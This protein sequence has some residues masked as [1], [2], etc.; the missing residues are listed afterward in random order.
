[1]EI[2]SE[3]IVDIEKPAVGG[4]IDFPDDDIGNRIEGGAA[5][6]TRIK[7][8][9]VGTRPAP[10]PE[11]EDP[12]HQPESNESAILESIAPARKPRARSTRKTTGVRKTA[13]KRPSTR[14]KRE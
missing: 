12:D 11:I 14:R 3:I 13:A 2:G 9:Q 1:M 7:L 10:G 5:D 4:P 8:G 6:L